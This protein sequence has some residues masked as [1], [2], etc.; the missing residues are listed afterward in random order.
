MAKARASLEAMN[1]TVERV[2]LLKSPKCPRVARC[3][4]VAGP[5]LALLDAEVRG[6]A[7]S[8]SPPEARRS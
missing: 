5:K 8:F 1:Y 7:E 2:S 4:V 3:L 6:A